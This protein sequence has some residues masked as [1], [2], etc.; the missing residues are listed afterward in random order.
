MPPTCDNIRRL[1]PLLG[2][3]VEVAVAGAAGADM[4][5]AVEAASARVQRGAFRNRLRAL[6]PR[7]GHFKAM[8]ERPSYRLRPRHAFALSGTCQDRAEAPLA[9]IP[10]MTR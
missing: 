10:R 8:G 9:P 6:L 5:A 1:R 7:L 4:A 3:F 2:T